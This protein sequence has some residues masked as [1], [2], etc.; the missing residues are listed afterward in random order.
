MCVFYLTVVEKI[1]LLI[2]VPAY[3]HEVWVVTKE[4]GSGNKQLKS[5]LGVFDMCLLAVSLWMFSGNVQLVGD[6]GVDFLETFIYLI[7]TGKASGSPRI[8]WKTLVDC[9]FAGC[10]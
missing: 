7:W 1:E 9:A 10:L 4:L 3:C 6:P 2:Y 5:Q 8:C